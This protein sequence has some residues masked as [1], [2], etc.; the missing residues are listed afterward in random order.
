MATRHILSALIVLGCA[1]QAAAQETPFR[2]RTANTFTASAEVPSPRATL[3]DMSWL[4][5]R[6]SGTGLGGMTEEMWSDP[7]SGAMMGMFR[8]VK[9]GKV[10]FYEFLTLVEQEGSL[11]LKLKHFNPDLTGWEEKADFITFRLLKLTPTEAFFEGITFRLEG[12][13]RLRI[14]VAI[15]NR[16]DGTVREEE[17]VQSRTR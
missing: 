1:T 2:N 9:D 7:A 14:F 17:F 3:Q 10:I 6:W 13:D 4:T 5:G 11:R 8:L 16:A 12:P 15:R